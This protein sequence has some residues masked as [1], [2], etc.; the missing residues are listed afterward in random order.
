MVWHQDKGTVPFTTNGIE[1][2]RIGGQYYPVVSCG[3]RQFN[4]C[5]CQVFLTGGKL[6]QHFCSLV[7]RASARISSES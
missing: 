1:V 6:W 4:C 5:C 2:C 7:I 3:R